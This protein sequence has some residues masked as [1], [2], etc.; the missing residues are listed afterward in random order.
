MKYS[1]VMIEKMA[2]F[3]SFIANKKKLSWH[4]MLNQVAS[5]SK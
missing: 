5:T 1:D 3:R 4:V 2:A